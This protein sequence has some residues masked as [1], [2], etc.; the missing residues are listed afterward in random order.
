MKTTSADMTAMAAPGFG[1]NR[2]GKRVSGGAGS[3]GRGGFTLIELLVVIA[4]IAILAA[5]LLPALSS[6][7]ERAKRIQCLGNLRQIVIGDTVY[8]GDSNDVLVK[9]R[10]QASVGNPGPG[11]VQLALNVSD[12]NGLKTVNLG[13]V[14]NV[15]SIW[16][17]P[18]RG[19]LP[20]WSSLQ[21][22]WDIGYQYFG[23][24]DEWVNPLAPNGMKTVYGG[25]VGAPPVSFSPIKLGQ[26]KPWWVL[27][28]DAVVKTDAGW[29]QPPSDGIEPGLYVNLPPHKKGSGMFPSGGNESFIDGSAQWEK[30][31]QMRFFTSWSATT[32]FCYFY[33]DRQDLP[34]AF[35]AHLDSGGMVPQ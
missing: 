12:A 25:Q 14:T 33:Q 22:Q 7:K 21:G 24:I 17:C 16:T 19:T 6:A 13:V 20:A 31:D 23:G 2:K 34:A 28:A 8:A 35:V 10:S 15:A 32:R 27:A 3:A 5:M 29:G 4:I 9:A 18:S 30:I 26:S 11:W 1:P